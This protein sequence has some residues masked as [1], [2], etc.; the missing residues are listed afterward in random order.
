MTDVTQFASLQRIEG[1]TANAHAAFIDYI[2]M[3][4][5][6][7]ITR[8]VD[9]YRAESASPPTKLIKTAKAW[10]KRNRWQDRVATYN[11]E[12][13]ADDLAEQDTFFREV[14]KGSRSRYEQIVERFDKML[15]RFE[16]LQIER[17]R[18]IRDPRDKHLP[19]EEQRE[20]L[21]VETAVNIQD[22]QRLTQ[23]YGQ[24]G[25]DLRAH[26]GMS[27]QKLDIN[28][29][30]TDLKKLQQLL[31]ILDEAEMPYSE[32]FEKMIQALQRQQ[33]GHG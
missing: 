3:G 12:S 30:L 22:L 23:I 32:V 26:H 16:E 21:M 25:K 18:V 19:L 13:A 27:N 7:S 11:L 2:L 33:V 15:L 1:E 14:R 17:R 28:L 6:R 24:V 5:K 29:N 10:S 4:S 31:D 9:G 8:L 20:M